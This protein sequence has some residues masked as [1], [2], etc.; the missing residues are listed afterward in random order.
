MTGV[1]LSGFLYNTIRYTG[2]RE[3]ATVMHALLRAF[4]ILYPRCCHCRPS[5]P[6]VTRRGIINIGTG[7]GDSKE[8]TTAIGCFIRDV[9]NRERVYMYT[10]S[11]NCFA[12]GP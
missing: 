4:Q 7:E 10:R 6:S 2:K 5:L 1:I 12:I 8:V 9:H 3:G 11:F